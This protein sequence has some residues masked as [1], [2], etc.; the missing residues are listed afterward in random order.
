[1]VQP[2]HCRLCQDTIGRTGTGCDGE[3]GRHRYHGSQIVLVGAVR[4]P[5]AFA[6]IRIDLIA[7]GKDN[8]QKQRG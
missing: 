5:R 8:Q 7:T 2:G 3:V 6:M 1:M 4:P